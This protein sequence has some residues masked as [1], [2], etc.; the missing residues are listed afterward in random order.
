[1]KISLHLAPP[2]LPGRDTATG[3][4]KKRE[5]GPWIFTIFRALAGLKGLRGTALDIFGYSAE[6]RTERALITEYEDTVNF[7]LA[8]LTA[9]NYDKAAALLA[10]PDMIRGFG[11]VKEENIAEARRAK[12]RI[13]ESWNTEDNKAG[14][15]QAAE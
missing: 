12:S 11:P 6:R 10:L 9:D 4:P 14:H 7:I 15:A 13:M 5:F 3:R 8:N 2:L 1:M